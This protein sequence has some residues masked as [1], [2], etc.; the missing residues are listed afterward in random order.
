[1]I[2]YFTICIALLF[3]GLVLA[4]WGL[5]D[6]VASVGVLTPIWKTRSCFRSDRSFRVFVLGRLAVVVGA[7]M[8]VIGT[9]ITL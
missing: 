5:H 9:L 3:G 8:T 2:L 1:M 4:Y 6:R 7:I